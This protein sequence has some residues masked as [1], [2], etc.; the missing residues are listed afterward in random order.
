MSGERSNLRE[1]VI[2]RPWTRNVVEKFLIKH[3]AA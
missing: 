2:L 3:V 1:R